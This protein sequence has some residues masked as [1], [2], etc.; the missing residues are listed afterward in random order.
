MNARGVVFLYSAGLV[1]GLVIVSVAAASAVLTGPLGL[2][3]VAYGALFVP[4]D[5]F[6]AA[7]GIGAGGWAH[8]V[9]LRRLLVL[10]LLAAAGSQAALAAASALPKAAGARSRSARKCIAWRRRTRRRGS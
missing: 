6:A 8:R 5:A 9:G 10:A 4:F 2:S 1:I 3:P 7:A